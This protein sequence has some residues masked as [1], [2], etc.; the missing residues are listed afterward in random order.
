MLV[1]AD[2]QLQTAHPTATE[3]S[4]MT[5]PAPVDLSRTAL[6]VMDYQ[7]FILGSY[8]NAADLIEGLPTP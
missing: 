1:A 8:P 7:P 5:T 2:S 6:L 3:E 4:E